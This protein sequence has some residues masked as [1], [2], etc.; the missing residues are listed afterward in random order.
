MCAH[1]CV[2]VRLRLSLYVNV[3]SLHL[4]RVLA[5]AYAHLLLRDSDSTFNKSLPTGGK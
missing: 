1:L 3:N 4:A 2:C 5:A